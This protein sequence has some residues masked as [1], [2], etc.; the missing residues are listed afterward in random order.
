MKYFQLKKNPKTVV[1]I[2]QHHSSK[3]AK[4][5]SPTTQQMQ[6]LCTKIDKT[7]IA[8]DPPRMEQILN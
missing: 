3:L 1:L 2:F 7:D 8:N 6:L 4:I 5:L